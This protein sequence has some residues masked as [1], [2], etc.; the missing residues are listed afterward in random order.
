MLRPSVKFVVR[1]YPLNCIKFVRVISK[2]Q[3]P[4]HR[5]HCISIINVTFV[6]CREVTAVYSEKNVMHITDCCVQNTKCVYVKIEG[7]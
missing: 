4:C 1:Q 2:N 3:F 7:T 5:K 6:V